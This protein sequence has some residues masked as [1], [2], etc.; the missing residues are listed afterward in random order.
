MILICISS[1]YDGDIVYC[2]FIELFVV[3]YVCCLALGCYN[4]GLGYGGVWLFEKSNV[5]WLFD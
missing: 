3:D 4:Y 2:R 5:G 1:Y